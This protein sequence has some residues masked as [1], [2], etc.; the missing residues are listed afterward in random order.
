MEIIGKKSTKKMTMDIDQRNRVKNR[1]ANKGIHLTV[2]VTA[3]VITRK[4]IKVGG[5]PVV[6]I[7][8]KRQRNPNTKEEIK[9]RN[10]QWIKNPFNL[11]IGENRKSTGDLDH[12]VDDNVYK[13]Q[14][15]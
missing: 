2:R 4:E 7:E 13:S 3:T 8:R 10:D 9:K 11:S 6:A 5:I 14:R 1:K 12:L 15:T